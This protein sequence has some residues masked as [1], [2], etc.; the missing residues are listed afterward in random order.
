MVLDAPYYC[1]QG[2]AFHVVVVVVVVADA[3]VDKRVLMIMGASEAIGAEEM[4]S[5]EETVRCWSMLTC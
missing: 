5:A 1:D 4:C 2:C 3:N